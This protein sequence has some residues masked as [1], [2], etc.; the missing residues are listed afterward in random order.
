MKFEAHTIPENLSGR[1]LTMDVG[2]IDGDGDLDIVLGSFAQGPP[3]IAI[4][5]GL[6]A[7]WQTNS[8]A[9][10]ILENKLR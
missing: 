8:V 2:D 9:G 4:P 6:R 10:L 3:S 7:R 5:A 1:W